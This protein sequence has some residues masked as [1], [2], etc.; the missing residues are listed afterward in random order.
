M[1]KKKGTANIPEKKVIPQKKR[2]KSYFCQGGKTEHP[3][4][5]AKAEEEG[6]VSP[7]SCQERAVSV[8]RRKKKENIER[9]REKKR[10]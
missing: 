5:M 3:V 9:K 1:G 6:I 8:G 10:V 4:A 7:W 2:G